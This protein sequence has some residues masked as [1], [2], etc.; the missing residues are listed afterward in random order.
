MSGD[1]V[2]GDVDK[3]ITASA[4][5][6]VTLVANAGGCTETY[7][8]ML[9]DEEFCCKAEGDNFKHVPCIPVD[10]V[11]GWSNR[12]TNAVSKAI[13]IQSLRL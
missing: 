12:Y 8:A 7:T 4:P 9:Y 11:E 6:E 3:P 10:I 13:T 1:Y 2:C 5:A